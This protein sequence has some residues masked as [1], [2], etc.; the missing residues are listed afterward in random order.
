MKFYER[1]FEKRSDFAHDLSY[2]F[3]KFTSIFQVKFVYIDDRKTY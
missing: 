2:D 3:A 1:K